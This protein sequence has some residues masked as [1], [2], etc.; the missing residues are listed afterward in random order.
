MEVYF[1]YG[2]TF[3]SNTLANAY[4]LV[5]GDLHLLLDLTSKSLNKVSR[6]PLVMEKIDTDIAL[7][8]TDRTNTYSRPNWLRVKKAVATFDPK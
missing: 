8:I 1:H 5:K 6:Q 3:N 4:S 2:F 7:H